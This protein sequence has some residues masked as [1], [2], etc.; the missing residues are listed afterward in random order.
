MRLLRMLFE[1][2]RENEEIFIVAAK[3]IPVFTMHEAHS[4]AWTL[5]KRRP[6]LSRVSHSI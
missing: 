4:W 5:D 1:V 2:A 3:A 6:P